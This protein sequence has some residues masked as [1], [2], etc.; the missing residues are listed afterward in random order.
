MRIRD[1]VLHRDGERV[2]AVR[3]RYHSRTIP[4]AVSAAGRAVIRHWTWR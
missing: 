2:D 3:L 4:A 1:A